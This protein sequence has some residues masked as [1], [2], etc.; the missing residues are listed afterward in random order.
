MCVSFLFL[1]FKKKLHIYGIF[2]Q[3]LY[4]N[5]VFLFRKKRRQGHWYYILENV[6]FFNLLKTCVFIYFRENRKKWK[7]QISRFFLSFYCAVLLL[8]W[9]FLFN[10]QC[11]YLS[12]NSCSSKNHFS[13]CVF[14]IS[15]ACFFIRSTI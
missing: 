12:F 14:P 5:G 7:K 6:N 3:F 11:L 2:P 10:N 9:C 4:E 1:T 13:K 8:L 15:F